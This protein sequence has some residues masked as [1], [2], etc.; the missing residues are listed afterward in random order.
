[1]T[2]DAILLPA[3]ALALWTIVVLGLVPFRRVSASLAGRTHVKDYRYGES[4]NVPGD[5]SLANRNYMNLLELPILFYFVCL[6]LVATNRVD[7]TYVY[8]AWAFVAM[9]VVHSL[10]HLTY[11]NVLHRL[12]VFAVGNILIA[13][14]LLRLTLS[15]L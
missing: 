4:A 8:L 3:C 1:M 12:M 7:Q 14:V 9:R 6:S 11:H 13:V 15:L 10:V 5:V 2:Q